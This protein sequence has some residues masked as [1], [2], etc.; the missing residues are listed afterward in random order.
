[1]L[2]ARKTG[3]HCRPLNL[4]CAPSHRALIVHVCDL[5][6]RTVVARGVGDG[7]GTFPLPGTDKSY[8]L[9][10]ETP[11]AESR[12]CSHATL[13]DPELPAGAAAYRVVY[14]AGGHVLALH[15]PPAE[16]DVASPASR[17]KT[18]DGLG[19][20]LAH[21]LVRSS[22]IFLA[23]SHPV[24]DEHADPH[25]ALTFG[26]GAVWICMR[27]DGWTGGA[28]RRKVRPDGESV[29]L[30][31]GGRSLAVV[32]GVSCSAAQE[33]D[34]PFAWLHPDEGCFDSTIKLVPDTAPTKVRACVGCLSP[35]RE[36][37]GHPRHPSTQTV[38]FTTLATAVSSG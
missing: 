7:S 5:V 23:V 31:V 1:M 32:A 14:S 13:I 10:H 26:S 6:N 25:L 11:T 16:P 15:G 38:G 29:E 21:A 28:M 9:A 8:C 30:L 36:T 34:T 19:P 2:L 22:L 37:R 27:A 4:P 24:V 33:R 17:T 35:H 20:P 18:T 3:C 12:W